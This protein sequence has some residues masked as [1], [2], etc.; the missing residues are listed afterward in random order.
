MPEN[1]PFNPRIWKGP[2]QDAAL[3]IARGYPLNRDRQARWD[4]EHIRSASCRLSIQ[5]YADFTA[6]CRSLG[7]TRYA[8]IRFCILAFLADRRRHRAYVA[9]DATR[10]PAYK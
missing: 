10:W 4:A 3:E 5:E 2:A 8:F 9:Q 6:E 1:T 7:I